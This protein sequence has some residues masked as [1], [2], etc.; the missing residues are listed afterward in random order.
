M[1]SLHAAWIAFLD[2]TLHVL[3]QT[4]ASRHSKAHKLSIEARRRAADEDS[5]RLARRETQRVTVSEQ[6]P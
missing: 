2:S 4:S 1:Q 5:Q 6:W 3:L